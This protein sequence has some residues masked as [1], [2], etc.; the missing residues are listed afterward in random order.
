MKAVITGPTGAIG[1]ALVKELISNNAEVLAIC[2]RGSKRI[3]HLSVDPH[4]HIL[5]LDLS[6]YASYQPDMTQKDYDIFYHFAWNGTTGAARND[7][8]MQ[9]ANIGYALDA[10]ALAKRMGCHTFIGAGSQAEYGRT[11]CKLNADVPTFPENGYGMA[12]L[13]AGQMTRIL[14]EQLGIKHI[15]TR[16]LSVYGPGD[17]AASMIMMTI[18]KLLDGEVPQLT[19][20]EQRWDYLYSGDAAR[21]MALLAAKGINGK[22]YCIGSGQTRCLSEYMEMMRDAVNPMAEMAIGAVPYSE[23]QVMYLCADIEELTHDTGFRPEVSPIDGIRETVAWMRD[24][25]QNF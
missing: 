10:A 9:H 22:T 11:E 12:K 25:S 17:G 23:K 4:V 13:A 3:G 1:I 24:S 14:C 20:G 2:H 16:I 5:E 19:K 15:W 6:E 18:R 21:A 7:M 8:Y